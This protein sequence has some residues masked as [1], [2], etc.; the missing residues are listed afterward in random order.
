MKRKKGVEENR[1][2]KMNKY[3]GKRRQRIPADN[4]T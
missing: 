3:V 2:K 1:K 4:N